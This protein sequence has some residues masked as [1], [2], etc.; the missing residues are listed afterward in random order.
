MRAE[1]RS[2]LDLQINLLSEQK[3]AKVIALLEE[4]RRDIPPIHNREDPVAHAMTKP[5]DPRAV[6]WA[7]EATFDAPSNTPSAAAQA[8]IDPASATKR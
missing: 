6:I 5:L 2:E 3:L 4:L 7:L 8:E 1:R